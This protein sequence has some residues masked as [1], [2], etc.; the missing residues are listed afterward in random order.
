MSPLTKSSSLSSLSL[1]EYEKERNADDH[2]AVI[3]SAIH[4]T[5]TGLSTRTTRI[6]HDIDGADLVNLPTRTLGSNA[7]LDEFLQ[8]TV[9]GQI[10][11]E[12]ILSKTG[13]IE[14]YE[15]VTW[16]VDDPENP[17]NWSKAFKW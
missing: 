6:G 14:R 5:Q 10:P 4:R 1:E 2:E 9:S 3:N 11:T 16:K 13:T 15:L 8:E 12:R 7:N 17:K